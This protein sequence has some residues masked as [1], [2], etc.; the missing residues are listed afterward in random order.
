M[1]K[2]DK[3]MLAWFVVGILF[4]VFIIVF[5]V[6]PMM[7]DTFESVGYYNSARAWCI[8]NGYPEIKSTGYD[9]QYFY[10]VREVGGTSEVIQA[11]IVWSSE[12]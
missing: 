6:A 5:G 7:K 4:V 2:E 3:I 10:C 9:P 8:E 12:K 1:D 11:P